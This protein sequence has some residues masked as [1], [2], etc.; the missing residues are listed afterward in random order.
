MGNVDSVP[1]ASQVKS[2]VCAARGES[3]AAWEIQRKFSQQCVGVAQVRAFVEVSRGDIEAAAETQRQFLETTRRVL[4]RSDIFDSVPGLSQMKARMLDQNGEAEA[5]LQTRENFSSRCFGVSQALSI[6]DFAD[7]RREHALARQREFLSYSSCLVDKIPVLGH[8][9]AFVHYTLGEHTRA[10]Q[11]KERASQS[12]NNGF[13]SLESA[14]HDITAHDRSISLEP[15]RYEPLPEV[16]R[17]HGEV[18]DR[19]GLPSSTSVST[20]HA[21][22]PNEIRENT[23]SFLVQADQCTS[24]AACPVC[25]QDFCEGDFGTTLQCFHIFHS[26]CII[27]WLETCGSCPVCRVPAISSPVAPM[28]APGRVSYA[29]IT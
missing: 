27:R 20:V 3:E 2:A 13:Q 29:L 28:G 18:L 5:A 9:K 23:F 8:V 1:V 4:N 10:E 11:A 25:M 15:P 21:L 24:F 6:F 12:V 19:S 17:S 16:Q 14:Y 7:N 26:S 22:T